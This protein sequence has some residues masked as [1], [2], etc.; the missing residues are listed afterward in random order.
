VRNQNNNVDIM[1]TLE[2]R[3][4]SPLPGLMAL[5]F[6]GGIVAGPIHAADTTN[7]P[8]RGATLYATCAECHGQKGEG[9]EA[10]KA[11]RLAGREDWFIKKQ[12]EDFRRRDRGKD[13]SKETGFLPPEER[14]QFMHPVADKLTGGDIKAIIAHLATLRPNPITPARFG[15]VTRGGA[16]YAA[17]IECHGKLAEGSSRKGAPRLT[18]QHDWYLFTQLRDFRMGWRGS[19]SK[20]PHVKLMRSRLDLDDDA[21]HDLAAYIVSLNLPSAAASTKQS[22]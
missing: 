14:T 20:E 2:R 22:R 9:I 19:D 21:L 15:D 1:N 6:L 3:L 11:P 5:V 8:S 17:C 16:L 12:V 13:D 18:G 4:N 7:K 10:T